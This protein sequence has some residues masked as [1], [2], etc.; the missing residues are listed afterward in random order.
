MRSAVM[1]TAGTDAMQLSRLRVCLVATHV[2]DRVI[3][4][5][6]AVSD[7]CMRLRPTS[8]VPGAPRASAMER[9]RAPEDQTTVALRL[10]APPVARRVGLCPLANTH[11]GAAPPQKRAASEPCTPQRGTRRRHLGVQDGVCKAVRER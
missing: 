5:P 11:T 6:S 9:A 7:A 2:I 3:G 1:C 10:V 4:F 8:M